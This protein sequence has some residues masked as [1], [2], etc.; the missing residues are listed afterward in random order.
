MIAT[1]AHYPTDTVGGFCTAV[2]A[3]LGTALLLD[4][5]RQSG[6]VAPA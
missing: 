2:V 6:D 4:R 3:V 5:V 1:N